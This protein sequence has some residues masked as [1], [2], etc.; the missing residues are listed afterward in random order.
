MMPSPPKLP[1]LM[2]SCPSLIAQSTMVSLTHN[3]APVSPKLSNISAD[4]IPR[5]LDALSS[6]QLPHQKQGILYREDS[7]VVSPA[8]SSVLC[9]VVCFTGFPSVIVR[10]SWLDSCILYHCAMS[11]LSMSCCT[12]DAKIL[13]HA[14]DIFKWEK[15]S[16]SRPITTASF[17]RASITPSRSLVYHG[18]F[19]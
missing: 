3:F 7:I 9:C 19:D 17:S 6:G 8:V 5:C 15:R 4:S 2:P 13:T 18:H 14:L 10:V 12:V 1:F 16:D 11:Q